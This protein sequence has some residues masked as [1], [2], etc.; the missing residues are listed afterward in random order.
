[1]MF[2]FAGTTFLMAL[3]NLNAGGVFIPNVLV[4]MLVFAGGLA[5][6]LVS[7]MEFIRGYTLYATC[8]MTFSTFWL[9]YGAVLI[10]SFG[11]LE[12]FTDPSQI[13]KALGLY[14]FVWWIT[15]TM[16]LIAVV[17]KSK[18]F[19]VLLSFASLAVLILACGQFL[20]MAVLGKV[21]S[22]LLLVVVA[23]AYYIG[24]AVLLVSEPGAIFT[25][26]IF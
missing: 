5:L 14:L 22:A 8:F 21:G 2:A 1:G 9:S 26:P 3:Y 12:A 19:T 16:L 11:V 20:S 25:L 4:G 18:L 13:G 15:I 7:I 23:L 6:T 24:L 10:P 17:G